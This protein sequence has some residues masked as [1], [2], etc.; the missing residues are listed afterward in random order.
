[1]CKIPH[2]PKIILFFRGNLGR[3]HLHHLTN[4]PADDCQHQN[5]YDKAAHYN[6]RKYGGDFHI[7]YNFIL[8][9]LCNT[10]VEQEADRYTHD[11]S[12]G[13]PICWIHKVFSGFKIQIG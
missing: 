4:L 8:D 10:P 13:N 11:Q 2:F 12:K 6:N 3:I 7:I 5:Y 1:M 9:D